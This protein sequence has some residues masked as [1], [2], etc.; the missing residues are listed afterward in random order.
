MNLNKRHGKKNN[1][2][3]AGL[4]INFVINKLKVMANITE[5]TTMS[6]EERLFKEYKQRA[7]DFLKIEMYRPALKWFAEARNL[8]I[9]NESIDRKIAGCEAEIRK[10][11]RTIRIIALVALVIIVVVFIAL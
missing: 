11:S 8:D 5:S 7:E 2:F 1:T 6:R 9:D 4:C 10:E 3:F